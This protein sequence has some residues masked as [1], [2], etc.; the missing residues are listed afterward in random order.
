MSKVLFRKFPSLFHFFIFCFSL[1]CAL[2]LCLLFLLLCV[3]CSSLVYA[4]LYFILFLVIQVSKITRWVIL[5]PN[6]V[7][8]FSAVLDHFTT[9][10]QMFCTVHALPHTGRCSVQYTLSTHEALHCRISILFRSFKFFTLLTLL[11]IYFLF[12]FFL[13]F[14]FHSSVPYPLSVFLQH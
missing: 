7:Q 3:I 9:Y 2:P 10:W 6:L 1:F 13:Y 11:F 4:S 12:T 14:L 8:I 5:P